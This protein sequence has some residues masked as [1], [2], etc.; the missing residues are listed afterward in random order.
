MDKL[1]TKPSDYDYVVLHMPN[2]KF[3]CKAAEILGF[4]SSKL[5]PGLIVTKIGNTYSGSS[6]L[7]LC[8]TLDVAKPGSRILLTSFGSGAGSDAISLITTEKL[9]ERRDKAPKTDFYINR[10]EYVSYGV[11]AKLRGKI[12]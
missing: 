10:K 4:E 5:L 1:G 12:R 11:Y 7:G 3:P 8:A 2:G 9:L 6:P